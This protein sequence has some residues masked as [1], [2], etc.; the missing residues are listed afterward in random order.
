MNGFPIVSIVGLLIA[1]GITT[2]FAFIKQGDKGGPINQLRHLATM[3][4]TCLAL[5]ALVVFWERRSL[6]SIGIVWGNYG[7]WAIGII[8][9]CAI[10]G[11]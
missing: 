11:M 6:S 9:G 10:L 7:A 3:W 5:L 4:G 8:V 2:L 1:L